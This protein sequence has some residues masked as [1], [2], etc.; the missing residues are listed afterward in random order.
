MFPTDNNAID[1]SNIIFVVG[2]KFQKFK[3]EKG[4][5]AHGV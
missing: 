5:Q 1:I 4:K 3:N 2:H